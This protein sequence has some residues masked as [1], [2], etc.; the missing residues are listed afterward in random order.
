MSLG[1]IS[2]A[3]RSASLAALCF[4]TRRQVQPRLQARHFWENIALQNL[5]PII[6]PLCTFYVAC[7]IDQDTK[8]N[9]MPISTPSPLPLL[10]FI[11]WATLC[12]V[13]SCSDILPWENS[14]YSLKRNPLSSLH[15]VSS[16]FSLTLWVG[17]RKGPR[18][19]GPF[20]ESSAV[21][22]VMPASLLPS[23]L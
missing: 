20:C 23:P 18:A 2:L 8:L 17:A 7:N 12:P 11:K 4:K 16:L 21:L 19:Q 9:L 15:A 14:L 5:L 1:G 22:V 10:A 3:T 6:I 13:S